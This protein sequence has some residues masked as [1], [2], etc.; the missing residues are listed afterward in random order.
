MVVKVWV[1]HI[2]K[3]RPDCF[4]RHHKSP[5]PV[6]LPPTASVFMIGPAYCTEPS[7]HCGMGYIRGGLASSYSPGQR[8]REHP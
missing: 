3:K 1:P 5:G 8:M 2:P 6:D 4:Q 7:T